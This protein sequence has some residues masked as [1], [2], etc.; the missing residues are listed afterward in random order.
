ML[1]DHNSNSSGLALGREA[2]QAKQDNATREP[3]LTKDHLA[4]ILVCR[5]QQGGLPIRHIEHGI[6]GQPR[7]HLSHVRHLMPILAQAFDNLTVH[8]LV[9]EEV[10]VPVSAMG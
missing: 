9:G 1:A 2:R 10:H 4:K 7:L 8:T 5:Q 6:I 3:T